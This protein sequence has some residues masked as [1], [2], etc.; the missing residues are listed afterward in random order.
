MIGGGKKPVDNYEVV[1]LVSPDGEIVRLN[2]RVPCEYGVEKWLRQVEV[3]MKESLAKILVDAH[4]SIKKRTEGQG[5]RWVSDWISKFPGQLLIVASQIT[6]TRDC[7]DVLKQLEDKPLIS[8][9]KT[10]KHVREDKNHF[11]NELTKLVRKPGSEVDREKL[12]A[13][14]T[15]EVHA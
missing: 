11:I 8:V 12:V 5:F 9:S 14:I 13:L 6:W 10:W 7:T 3:K 2:P 4:K 1:S 15:I